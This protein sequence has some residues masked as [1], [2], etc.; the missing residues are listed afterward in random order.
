[1]RKKTILKLFCILFSAS[2]IMAGCT[3]A[4][5]PEPDPG[6]DDTIVE[7]PDPVYISNPI[8]QTDMADPHILRWE[9]SLYIYS[10][11]GK[12]SRSDD[13]ATWTKVG[14]VGISPTGGTGAA[15][16][17]AGASCRAGRGWSGRAGLR[18]P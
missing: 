10:T 8:T 16:V 7:E 1:M 5:D 3:P 9:D 17:G 14:N 11:G 4:A 18:S 12:I 2:L 13:G 15:G 6:D